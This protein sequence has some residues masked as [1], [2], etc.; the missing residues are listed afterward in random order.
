MWTANQAER[1]YAET[2]KLSAVAGRKVPGSGYIP[3]VVNP[4][5]VTHNQL[6]NNNENT[7]AAHGSVARRNR[8]LC[9]LR[10]FSGA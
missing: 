10:N 5:D 1:Y 8:A 7:S 4:A 6:V 9:A 2:R 3:Y